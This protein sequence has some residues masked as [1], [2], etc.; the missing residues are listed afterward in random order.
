MCW[1]DVNVCILVVSRVHFSVLCGLH[2]NLHRLLEELWKRNCS[3]LEQSK[4]A[5]GEKLPAGWAPKGGMRVGWMPNGGALLSFEVFGVCANT[6]ENWASL[7]TSI[8]VCY[9][10]DDHL[11]TGPLQGIKKNMHEFF[12]VPIASQGS[13]RTGSEVTAADGKPIG[14]SESRGAKTAALTQVV[15][16]KEQKKANLMRDHLQQSECVKQLQTQTLVAAAH[17]QGV[18]MA[19]KNCMLLHE[20]SVKM[21]EKKCAFLEKR[22]AAALA[23]H[24]DAQVRTHT[25]ALNTAESDLMVLY[26]QNP[27]ADFK[28]ESLP[29]LAETRETAKKN[30]ANEMEVCE[31]T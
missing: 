31:D 19:K 22:V 15:F 3:R 10:T 8:C 12:L 14:R 28:D 11:C 2:H 13:G 16:E 18:A 20:Q 4:L 30:L 29:T 25:A 21:A 6:C 27:L 9:V 7:N 26:D 17:A 24:N 1:C 5:P 23:A